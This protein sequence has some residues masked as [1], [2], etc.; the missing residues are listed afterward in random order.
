MKV[1]KYVSLE[2]VRKVMTDEEIVEF[3]YQSLDIH[4]Q[5]M[6]RNQILKDLKKIEG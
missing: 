5:R 6:L 4:K 1:P 3:V 2:D